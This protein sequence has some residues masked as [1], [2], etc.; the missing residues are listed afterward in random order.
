[1]SVALPE[2]HLTESIASRFREVVA[3]GPDRL[4]VHGEDASYTYE[5]LDRASSRVA[6]FLL[7]ELGPGSEPIALLA[8]YGGQM[9]VALMG[10]IRAGKFYVPLDPSYP[11]ARNRAI[12]EDV[13]ARLLLT[14]DA[15]EEA[16]RRIAQRLCGTV[17][18]DRLP[19]DV[20]E[21]DPG[22]DIPDDAYAY[23][24]Y[25]SGT[26]GAPKGVI[27]NHRD[28]LH[29]YRASRERFHM[30][31]NSR[32]LLVAPLIFSGSIP[33]IFGPLLT[34]GSVFPFD[35]RA[36][37]MAT[38]LADWID[39][40]R[41]TIFSSVP[42]LFRNLAACVRSEGRRLTSLEVL[43]LGGDRVLASDFELYRDLCSDGCLFTAGYGMSEV[44]F[45]TQFQARR[46]DHLGHLVVPAGWSH[47]GSEV[48]LLDEDG[49][50]VPRGEV[51]E[52]VVWTAFA[53]PGYWKRP[54]LTAARFKQDGERTIFYTGD[55]GVQ[56][57]D[58]CFHHLGRKDNQV[59]IRGNR[60]ELGEVEA[61]LMRL[62]G[63]R[64]ALAVVHDADTTSPRLVAYY[65]P[66]EAARPS[67]SQLRAE[68]REH[69]PEYMVPAAYVPVA[70]FPTNANGK[71][72]RSRLPA[73]SRR[74]HRI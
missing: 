37:G 63:V 47:A 34:G 35:C 44:K 56:D 18:A 70:S 58:G 12:L 30:R 14:G 74:E 13:E 24:L 60:V 68:L 22:V 69:L 19:G 27:E 8:P 71:L 9:I 15:T 28:V 57:A 72:D 4:A 42:S 67:A 66:A 65:V 17:S 73:P 59:K 52:F 21:T 10:I 55:L 62:P 26:T 36:K 25:T 43:N 54:E 46:S 38:A 45:I 20:A 49:G 51:G 7:A 53:S 61:A 16:G 1:M 2:P 40:N 33:W 64:D 50:V 3:T 48:F 31:P 39:S 5:A 41:L 11:D 6:N 29:I 32:V 23:V